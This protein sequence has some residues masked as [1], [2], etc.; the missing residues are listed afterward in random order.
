MPS[1]W[2]VGIK[3]MQRTGL[4]MIELTIAM[5]VFALALT[6]IINLMGSSH[7]VSNASAFELMAVHYAAELGEQIQRI[8]PNLKDIKLKTGKNLED[9]L[10]SPSVVALLGPGGNLS[11]QAYMVKLTDPADLETD[12]S[13]FVSPINPAFT[14]RRFYVKRLDNTSPSLLVYN[15]G[16]GIFWDVTISLSWKLSPSN[17]VTHAASYSFIIREDL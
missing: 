17:P 3:I 4:S 1:V 14:S 10:T 13:L 5:S 9:L 6:P 16:S 12:I 15:S 2:L 11:G 8:S 7:R